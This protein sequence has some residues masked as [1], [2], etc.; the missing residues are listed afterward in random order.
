MNSRNP[1]V[2]LIEPLELRVAPASVFTYT[3]VDGDRVT[4]KSSVG[5]LTAAG[6]VVTEP[7]GQGQQLVLLDL[8]IAD[9]DG[10]NIGFTVKK[11]G[12]GDGLVN[13]GYINSTGQNL[14]KV[15]VKGDLGQIDAGDNSATL[16]AIKSLTVNSVGRLGLDTQSGASPSLESD[17]SGK[18]GSLTVKRDIKDAIIDV[19]GTNGS[20]GKVTINGSIIGG[21]NTGSGSIVSA[22]DIGPVK[23]GRDLQGGAGQDSGVI[24]SVNGAITRITI[25]GSIIG[26]SGSGS[27]NISSGENI[28]AVKIG[29][30]IQGGTGNGSA[31]ID[32][33]GTL[34]KVTVNG[35]LSGGGSNNSGQ[36]LSDADMG[37]VTINQDLLG[38]T[39]DTTGIINAGGDLAGVTIRGSLACAIEDNANQNNRA[40]IIANGDI[41][42]VKIGHN[43]VGA[44]VTGLASSDS[45]ASIRSDAGRIASVMVGGSITAGTD[46]SNGALTNNASIR[47]AN[48][49]GSITVKGSII[50]TTTNNGS[51]PVVITARGQAVQGATTDVA[52]GKITVSGRVENALILGGY[53][54]GTLPDPENSDAQIGPVNVTGDWI[55]SSLVAGVQNANFPD[56][57]EGD[58]PIGG[59]NAN[60]L[61]RI[62]S[63][64]IKGQVFGTPDSVSTTDHFGF[65]AEQ[66]GKIKISGSTIAL[67]ANPQPVGETDDMTVNIIV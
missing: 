49:I 5:D 15:S 38:G 21:I 40:M 63:I 30:N 26:E 8:T 66:F 33:G 3:D 31:V 46:N 36:I 32:S 28:G 65:V 16:P 34:G 67:S 22:N 55:A 12:G 60:V 24:Q 59:G 14:G 11:T 50:G 61:S 6:V 62:A 23:I 42:S 17:I 41:G 52:I 13:V 37:R 48:D 7:L 57:G 19:S 1:P 53:G 27:A 10:A 29:H 20:I 39:G 45:T 54:T 51:S 25:N 9:F 4:I 47:A 18:L 35:F 44:S 64:T 43:M 2:G 58:T 56:F